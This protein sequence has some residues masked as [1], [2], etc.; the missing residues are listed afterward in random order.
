[1]T[2]TASKPKSVKYLK[3]LATLGDYIRKR[4]LDMRLMQK[5]VANRI[6][7]DVEQFQVSQS[8][9]EIAINEGEEV[10]AKQ[11]R[12]AFRKNFP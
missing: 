11:G 8:E 4:R 12:R 7:V 2:L 1:V 5:E 6:G 3:K 9:V 10:P